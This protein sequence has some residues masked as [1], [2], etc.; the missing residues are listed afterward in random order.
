M[1][2]ALS[3]YSQIGSTRLKVVGVILPVGG[4]VSETL[5]ERQ[6][7]PTFFDRPLRTRIFPLRPLEMVTN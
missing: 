4:G 3:L 6:V 5:P 7:P 1:M 2:E